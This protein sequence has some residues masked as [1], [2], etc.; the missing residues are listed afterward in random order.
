[1]NWHQANE[2]LSLWAKALF[3]EQYPYKVYITIS[4]DS[5]YCTFKHLKY[6]DRVDIASPERLLS[7]DFIFN[8]LKLPFGDSRLNKRD[9]WEKV[10]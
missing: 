2:Q 10:D 4:E 1:M 3:E 8:A 7:H 6:D 9:D 5:A